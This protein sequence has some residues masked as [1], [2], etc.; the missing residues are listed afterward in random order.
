MSETPGRYF[1]ER[2]TREREHKWLIF[3]RHTGGEKVAVV[4]SPILAAKIVDKLN[5]DA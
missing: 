3:D 4:Y 1:F 2:V 5:E